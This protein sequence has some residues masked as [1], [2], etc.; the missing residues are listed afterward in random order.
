MNIRK[1][2]NKFAKNSGRISMVAA[3][4]L[5]GGALLTTGVAKATNVT[6]A[7]A[8][9]TTT[10]TQQQKLQTIIAK[11][12]QEINRRLATLNTL[13]NKINAANKLTASDKTALINEVNNT[14]SGLTALKI[15]LDGETTITAAK[16]D[17]QNI[18]LEYRVYALVAPK[19]NLI[20]VADDQQVAEAKLTTLAQKLQARITA[21]KQAGKD[22]TSLQN[23]L[24]DMTN[25]INAAQSISS[26]I[27]SSVI[28]LQPTDY[29]NDHSILSGDNVKLANAHSDNVK[30]LAD[31][32]NIV[33]GLKSL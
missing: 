5:C 11:G 7:S 27:E 28:N 1:D 25:N 23:E 3:V 17:V 9:T 12:D 13:T 14:I 24:N 16:T 21:D 6:T 22:V 18:Y 19:V 31:A 4:V 30:A 20:K 2:F 32:K 10:A 33:S 8:T 26:S 15:Q 29:N